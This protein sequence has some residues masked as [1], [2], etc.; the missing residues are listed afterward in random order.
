[1]K[2]RGILLQGTIM[3]FCI[4]PF[5]SCRSDH[6]K[7]LPV[8]FTVPVIGSCILEPDHQYYVSL[9]DQLDPREKIPLLII[10]DPHGDGLT[11]LQKFTA[12]LED[13]PV[14][15]AA[16]NKL[17][18]N[19]AGFEVSLEN[20][21]N[22]L[23]TKYPVDPQ[24]IIVAGFSGG[25]RMALYYGI[26]NPVYGIIMF[27]AG[28]GELMNRIQN[29][30]IY[31][32]SGTRDFNFIEQ[33][34]PLFTN[35]QSGSTYANDYFRGTHT[36]P[37]ERYLRE[38]FVYCL[39]DASKSFGA[40]SSDFSQEFLEEADSL[41]EANDLFFAGKALEKAWCFGRGKQ[42]RALS[43]K[44][45]AFKSNPDWITCQGKIESLLKSEENIKRMYAGTPCR[46]G[47]GKLV[48]GIE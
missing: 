21:K 22:D 42:K 13:L 30:R 15:I 39:R 40:I 18:N 28:P 31:A 36:W 38:G 11:A 7:P 35:I 6:G 27:G 46:S 1:M 17:R 43:G 9:P 20:L 10:I 37:S 23:I 33:Y 44:I 3:L 5:L 2:A 48:K 14:V 32:A 12:A 45:D 34:R 41:Q 4:L 29:K 26:K 47:Y 8:K 16:S 25:A 24:K 19:A